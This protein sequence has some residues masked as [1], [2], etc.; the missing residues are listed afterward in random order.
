MVEDEYCLIFIYF[1]FAPTFQLFIYTYTAAYDVLYCTV[2]YC[3]ACY[4][5]FCDIY[6]ILNKYRNNV[7]M[8][9]GMNNII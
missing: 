6:N 1:L 4:F 5:I 7:A 2:L 8:F 3:T 9:Y